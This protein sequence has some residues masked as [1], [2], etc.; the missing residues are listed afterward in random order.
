MKVNYNFAGIN[1]GINSEI[2]YVESSGFLD[3]ISTDNQKNDIEVKLL[4]KKEKIKGLNNKIFNSIFNKIY[5]RENILYREYYIGNSKN[6]TSCFIEREKDKKYY[7]YVYKNNKM[8]YNT[9][10]IFS[11]IGFEYLLNLKG[12]I[13]LHSSQILHKGKS[14]LFSAPSQTGKSTQ[15]DLWVKYENAELINGDRSAIRKVDGIW[16][17]YG[18]PY[19]GSSKVYKNIASPIGAIV[20]LRQGKINEI[21]KA[22]K[23][24][25]FKYIYSET[26]VNIWNN[27]F[28]NR[29]SNIIDGLINDVPIYMYYCLPDKSAVDKLKGV[30]EEDVYG[31]TTNN[32]LLI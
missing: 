19:A 7:C 24:E 12:A 29:T 6:P 28:I 20:I 10:N 18:L 15:A 3:F 2:P 13:I 8:D 9:F 11:M 31:T 27:E 16:T 1:I 4:L 5:M 21:R 26:T 17:S 22:T 32:E 25:A 14:I 30:L 23:V